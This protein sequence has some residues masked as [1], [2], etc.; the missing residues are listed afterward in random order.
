MLDAVP[1]Q[2]PIRP[3]RRVEYEKLVELGVFDDERIEL[4]RGMLVPMSPQGPGHAEIPHRLVP[5]LLRALENRA[6]VHFHSPLALLDDTE[7]EPDVAIVPNGDYARALPTTA[8]LAVEVSDSSLRKDRDLKGPIY[9]K[10]GIPEYWIVNLKEQTLEV[11]RDP[12][13]SEERYAT[14]MTLRRG[15]RVR[16]RAFEDIEL[17]I[18]EILGQTGQAG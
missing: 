1:S 8:L 18:D 9:A 2:Q 4:L 3:L 15:E 5:R 16:V 11:Y 10:A 6:R 17:T 13:P 14:V 7:P 12:S